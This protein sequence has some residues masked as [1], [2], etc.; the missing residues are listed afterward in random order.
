MNLGEMPDDEYREWKRA[1]AGQDGYCR[2]KD[3][4]LRFMCYLPIGHDGD[5]L[6]GEMPTIE[7]DE[8][9]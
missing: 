5:H 8:P 7:I 9:W 2:A 1:L 3:P 4:D 6:G